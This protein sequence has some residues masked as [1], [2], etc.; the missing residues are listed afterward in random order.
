MTPF[1]ILLVF[2]GLQLLVVTAALYCYIRK[3]RLAYYVVLYLPSIAIWV[4]WW[5]S[6][7]EGLSFMLII[8]FALSFVYNIYISTSKD[9]AS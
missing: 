2:V 8:Q 3:W 4:F 6:A 7:S 9:S 1:L 5:G